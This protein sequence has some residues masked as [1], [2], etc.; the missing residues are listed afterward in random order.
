MN[1]DSVKCFVYIILFKPQNNA[2]GKYSYYYSHFIDEI[3][4]SKGV[5]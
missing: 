1:R 5:R 4:K 3:T 2:M